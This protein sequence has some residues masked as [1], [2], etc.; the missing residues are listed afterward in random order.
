[1][2]TREVTKA[3]KEAEKAKVLSLEVLDAILDDDTTYDRNV[4]RLNTRCESFAVEIPSGLDPGGRAGV[5]VKKAPT[6]S[7]GR[8]IYF[9]YIGE[10]RKKSRMTRDEESLYSKRM[11]F[12]RRRVVK[13]V[14]K[15]GHPRK[16]AE[17]FLQNTSCL[18]HPD[19]VNIGPL[20]EQLGCCPRGK[21]DMIHAN[22][23]AYNKC[24]SIFVERN[25]HLVVN[26]TQP[27]RTYGVPIMDLIQEGNTALIRAVEKFDWRKGVRFQ[28]YAAFWVRQAVERSISANKGIVRVPNYIQQKMRRFRREGKISADKASVSARDISD[29]FEM[30]N[31][32]AGRLLETERGHISLDAVPVN[33]EG[34]SLS[35][36]I[37]EEQEDRVPIEEVKALKKRLSE[38]LDV[39]TEQERIILRHRFGLDKTELKTLDELGE[40]MNLSRERVRQVQIRALQK[41]KK[42]RLLEELQSFL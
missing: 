14:G 39:L 40:I 11:E 38:A 35:D 10:V 23:R 32:V 27:Y 17:F 3:I 12:F 36:L 37:A 26:L 25:L 42:P 7:A 6:Y 9:H 20:C 1:M 2:K 5:A 29:V 13:A 24:R 22:C 4:D 8:D 19:S 28:T 21:R 33:G 18:G 15:T 31:E 41:L 34:S 30:S 16:K